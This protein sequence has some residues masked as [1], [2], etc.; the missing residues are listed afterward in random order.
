[1][2]CRPSKFQF[3][4]HQN[5]SNFVPRAAWAVVM[6]FP[7]RA[8]NVAAMV[9][10]WRPQFSSF[11]IKLRGREMTKHHLVDN[12]FFENPQNASFSPKI[13]AMICFRKK[14]GSISDSINVRMGNQQKWVKIK[15]ITSSLTI[16]TWT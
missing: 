7:S 15:H 2:G 14:K 13:G 9:E 1:M 8:L 3:F 10:I 6:L 16:T 12:I 11:N 5:F 4:V